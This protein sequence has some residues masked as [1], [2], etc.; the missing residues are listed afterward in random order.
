MK[1][2]RKLLQKSDYQ[3]S[4][5][6]NYKGDEW[7][8]WHKFSWLIV[9]YIW[10][11]SNNMS[12]D[13]AIENGSKTKSSGGKVYNSETPNP[14]FQVITSKFKGKVGKTLLWLCVLKL[15]FLRIYEWWHL[16]KVF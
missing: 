16:S 8:I 2:Y 6:K 9:T 3:V 7:F 5:Y 10:I 14:V 1:F 15:N 13:S 4:G 11:D 12:S